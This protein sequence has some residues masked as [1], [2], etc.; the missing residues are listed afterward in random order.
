ML[1]FSG[2]FGQKNKSEKRMSLTR[3]DVIQ[4]LYPNLPFDEVSAANNSDDNNTDSGV[5]AGSSKV[6]RGKS[7]GSSGKRGKVVYSSDE[8][9][10]EEEFEGEN[11]DGDFVG[12]L[13]VDAPLYESI[14]GNT[15][16]VRKSKCDGSNSD[17]GSEQ[18]TEP[19]CVDNTL[20]PV[21][22]SGDDVHMNS[23][24]VIVKDITDGVLLKTMKQLG[25]E[26]SGFIHS[27]VSF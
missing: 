23:E 6:S 4:L 19:Q 24:D 25:T 2:G 26:V 7:S 12:E 11:S 10:G 8:S 15:S 17:S 22:N 5:K 1:S 27:T 21:V 18:D 16:G 9:E 14:T 3:K 13:D 20:Y